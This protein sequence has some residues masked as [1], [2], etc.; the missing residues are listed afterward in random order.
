MK[1]KGSKKSINTV[2]QR[3]RITIITAVVAVVISGLFFLLMNM[4]ISHMH[5]IFMFI[6]GMSFLV[7]TYLVLWTLSADPKY[8]RLA[9][10]LK[11]CYIVCVSLGLIFFIILQII[12]ISG[13]RTEQA[14]VDVIIILGAGLINDRPSLILASRLN[15]AIAYVQT[16]DN[17][18]IITTGGLG[19]G[20]TVTEA[21]A[22]ARYLIARGIDESRIWKEDKSTNS[23]ENINFAKAIMIE[24]GMDTENIKV[25]IVTNEFHL[26]R[27]KLTAQKAGLDPVGVAAETPGLHRKLI[28]YFRE[29]FSLL[30]EVIFR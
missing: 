30:N 14:D 20:R 28:Y 10:I 25:A 29:A 21:E 19:Q 5:V 22:M 2:K 18:P 27:A 11:R 3:S 6:S 17:I 1:S 7:I 23:H 13:S 26:Y 16:R 15:A 8:L 9:K 24:N 4:R 12:I